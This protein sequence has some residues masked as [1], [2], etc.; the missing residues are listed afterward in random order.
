VPDEAVQEQGGSEE[1]DEAREPHRHVLLDP[2]IHDDRRADLEERE[3]E[4]GLERLAQDG[5]LWVQEVDAFV[6]EDAGWEG[7]LGLPER[8]LIEQRL[9]ER[10]SHV[11]HERA[12]DAD[13]EHAF[14]EPRAELGLPRAH[15]CDPVRRPGVGG[16]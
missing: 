4:R 13:H 16:A 11:R 8:V 12:E 2:E 5:N 3:L 14:D 6:V 1:A 9:V 7:G 15:A 10:R